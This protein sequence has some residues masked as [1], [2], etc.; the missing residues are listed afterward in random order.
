MNFEIME[1]VKILGV[2]FSK[3]T[4]EETLGKIADAAETDSRPQPYHVITANPEIV[5]GANQHSEL[6]R[7]TDDADLITP[8]GIGIVMASRW[9]GEPVAERVAGYDLLLKLLERGNQKGWSFFFLGSSE[10]VNQIA[11]DR[12]RERYPNIRIVGRHHG[13]F[14]DHEQELVEEINQAR[15]QFLI[16][17]LGAPRQEQWIYLHKRQLKANVAI[18]VGGCLDV[19]AGKV[20]RAPVFWQKLNLEWLYRLLSQPSRWKRQLALPHFA[21]KAFFEAK[22]K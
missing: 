16:V 4:M 13:F 7:I 9:K 1:Q 14:K 15:P 5:M 22:W 21:I 18:G 12:I 10:E 17:A 3:L 19:I 6:K 20:K 11:T 8:D 2:T